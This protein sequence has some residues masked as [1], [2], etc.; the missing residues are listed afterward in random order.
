M[1]DVAGYLRRISY[2]GPVRPDAATLTAL[3]RAHLAAV[4]YENLDIQLGRP[5]TL[6]PEALYD[7]IVCRGRG[8]F[9]FELNGAFGLLLTALGFEVRHVEGAVHRRRHGEAAWGNHLALLVRTDRG[10]M[11]ADVG[12]GD[13][14][15][16]PLPLEIGTYRQ[17]PL[18]YHLRR[19][20]SDVWRMVHHPDGNC[21]GFEFRTARR[22]LPDFAA[23]CTRLGTDPD[24]PFVRALV[25]QQARPDHSLT[26]RARSLSRRGPTVREEREIADQADFED[27]LAGE[28]GVP[29]ATLDAA[30]RDRL[31]HN[32]R[33]QHVG[34]LAREAGRP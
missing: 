13:G 29:V 4:P 23:R 30:S 33:E 15:L 31:W 7:K 10:T 21:E 12:L 24:S 8:G 32:A 6:S 25:V 16:A 18:T 14:F 19:E 26:L 20:L 3:H 17:G 34:W 28:F 9:C 22:A 11:V 2:S 27:V 1:L 5:P